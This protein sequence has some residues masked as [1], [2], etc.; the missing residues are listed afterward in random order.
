MVYYFVGLINYRKISAINFFEKSLNYYS[1]P[2]HSYLCYKEI[3]IINYY[4]D[5]FQKAKFY[6]DKAEA[7][8]NDKGDA[9]LFTFLGLVYYADGNY[10][11]AKKYLE[12]AL[13][14][15]GNFEWIKKEFIFSHL[16]ATEYYLKGEER[17]EGDAD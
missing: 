17:E 13:D 9:E 8:I 16:K 4:N 5:R 6:L 11:S 2:K 12:K 14:K 7:L 1:S 10:L 3:G 15:Y